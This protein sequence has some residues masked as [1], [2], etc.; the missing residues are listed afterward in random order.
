[1]LAE[2]PVSVER[3]KI[4]RLAKET[5]IDSVFSAHWGEII[6]IKDTSKRLRKVVS[7]IDP[8]N[9]VR[10]LITKY[11]IPPL[12]GPGVIRLRVTPDKVIELPRESY[13]SA[14]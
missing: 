8:Q 10:G 9:S 12:R 7:V 3:N 5:D 2:E 6:K 11:K 13:F 1:M 14:Y 4:P